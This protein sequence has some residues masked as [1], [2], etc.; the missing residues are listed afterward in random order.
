MANSVKDPLWKPS[1]ERIEA[2]NITR[3]MRFVNERHSTSFADYFALYE[4]SIS[5]IPDFWAAAWDFLDIK[6]SRKY[7]RVVDDL[8]RFPGAGWFPGAEMNFAENLLRYS[9]DHT[10]IVFKAETRPPMRMT[11]RELS[12]KVALVANGLKELGVDSEDRVVGYMPN[13]PETAIAMLATTSIGATWASCGSEL[14]VQAVIDR[15]SQIP[16]KVLFTVDGYLYKN[17]PFMMLAD[18]RAVVEAVPSIEKVVVVPYA[19]VSPDIGA[20]RDA[21]FFDDFLSLNEEPVFTQVP[22][23]HPVYIMFSSGT[24]GKPKCMVQSVE[25]HSSTS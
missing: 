15:F 1:K 5:N 21:V 18:V 7:D 10:A 23:G 11:Y 6:A 16:P 22:A 14:G 25:G 9:D 17:K 2:A 13:V 19:S 8:G 24:T 12:A 20:I 4:W 3:F